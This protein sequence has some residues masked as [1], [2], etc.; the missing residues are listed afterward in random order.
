MARRRS[1]AKGKGCRKY[2]F[3]MMDND[4]RFWIAQEVADS[5]FKHDARSLLKMGKTVAKKVPSVFVTDGLPAYNDAFEKEFA[6]KNFPA[7]VKQ[8]RKRSSF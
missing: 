2:L 4:T 3:A 6:P 5:K 1:M 8:A 7:Q